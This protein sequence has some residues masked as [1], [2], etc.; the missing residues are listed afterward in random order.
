M[1][2]LNSVDVIR[3]ELLSVGEESYGLEQ[4]ASEKIE[5]LESVRDRFSDV[6]SYVQNFIDDL[7][8]LQ[9]TMDDFENA[10]DEAINYEI[11]A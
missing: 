11:Q 1:D 9:S 10:K 6:H 8:T 5:E 4:Q 7:D 2:I 3:E